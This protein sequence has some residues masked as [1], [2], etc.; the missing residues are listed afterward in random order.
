MNTIVSPRLVEQR[1]KTTLRR[2]NQN[3]EVDC[4]FIMVIRGHLIEKVTFKIFK[5][6]LELENTHAGDRRELGGWEGEWWW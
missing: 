5:Q 6:R 4:N 1:K 2:E 3:G